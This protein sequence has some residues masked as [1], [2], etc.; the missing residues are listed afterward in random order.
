MERNTGIMLSGG[1]YLF[2]TAYVA[3]P[4]LGWDLSAASM[5]AAFGAWPLAA[6]LS[7]KFLMAWPFTFHVFNGVRY[8]VTAAGKSL[9]NK[10]QIIKIGW[11]VTGASLM[12]AI[13]LAFLV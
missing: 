6:K 8:L 1:L 5:A 9:D 12:S 13:A 4:F 3:A 2:G 7:A 11:A 10:P